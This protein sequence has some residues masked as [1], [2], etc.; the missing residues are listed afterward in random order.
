M[1][2]E[3]PLT[4]LRTLP[5]S[6]RQKL[7]LHH[8]TTVERLLAETATLDRLEQLAAFLAVAPAALA[9]LV[10]EARAALK[11]ATVQPVA[12][13]TG[14][15]PASSRVGAS[16]ACERTGSYVEDHGGCA[17]CGRPI[18]SVRDIAGQCLAPGCPGQICIACWTGK[19]RRHCVR[20]APA[21]DPG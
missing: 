12:P 5:A 9:D 14:A 11:E 15:A 6:L 8:I 2:P 18:T 13:G 1:S 7:E 3:T 21:A 19:R 20:H 4:S 17:A 10:G 16:R